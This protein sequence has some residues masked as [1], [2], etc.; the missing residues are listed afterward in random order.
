MLLDICDT[1]ADIGPDEP[2]RA[3]R[4]MRFACAARTRWR[5][6]FL[7]TGAMLTLLGVVLA[8]GAVLI[9]GVLLLLFALLQGNR[10]S[11]LAVAVGELSPAR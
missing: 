6:M 9:P 11:R 8:G 1:P 5:A 10:A 2:A 3:G 4:M 7:I